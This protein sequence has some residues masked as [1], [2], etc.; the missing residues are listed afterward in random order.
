MFRLVPDISPGVIP[1]F[2]LPLMSSPGL[3]HLW[4]HPLVHPA[5][6]V[7]PGFNPGISW[8]SLPKPEMTGKRKGM[9]D[10]DNQKSPNATKRLS[11]SEISGKFAPEDKKTLRFVSF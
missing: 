9:P 8:L 5:P 11:E 1:W 10:N 3:T 2:T 6:D 4:Y 7:I